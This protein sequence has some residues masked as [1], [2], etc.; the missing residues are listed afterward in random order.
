MDRAYFACL[1]GAIRQ[2]AEALQPGMPGRP[3][4]ADEVEKARAAMMAVMSN[5]WDAV[6][7]RT[8]GGC[9]P[10]LVPDEIGAPG[11]GAEEQ[12]RHTTALLRA[13]WHHLEAAQAWVP[14]EGGPV[15][16][17]LRDAWAEQFRREQP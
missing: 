16:Y 7:P 15:R 11:Y 3:V 1:V 6:L 17:S 9:E 4:G 5:D 14:P 8:V 12:Q 2:T 13:G 10:G